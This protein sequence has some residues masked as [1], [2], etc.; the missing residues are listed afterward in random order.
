M[1]MFDFINTPLLQLVI[2]LYVLAVLVSLIY[3]P[4]LS[5][6][7]FTVRVLVGLSLAGILLWAGEYMRVNET[8]PHIFP[9]SALP[10]H[11]LTI[12]V[13]YGTVI[14][15]LL[16]VLG[17]VHRVLSRA[18]K[19]AGA[20]FSHEHSFRISSYAGIVPGVEFVSVCGKYPLFRVIYYKSDGSSSWR[21]LQFDAK[22]GVFVRDDGWSD[23]EWEA[24]ENVAPRM[25]EEINNTLVEI[26]KINILP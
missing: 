13:L 19:K 24:L 18:W 25:A 4:I 5:E 7:W 16:F 6:Y 26:E 8:V 3:A 1:P 15:I 12:L 9:L 22:N 21:V 11:P 23:K 14:S 10:N 20:E 17:A 2:F